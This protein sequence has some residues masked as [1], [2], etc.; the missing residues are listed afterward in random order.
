MFPPMIL[1]GMRSAGIG[2]ID[3]Y[4]TPLGHRTLDAISSM[5]SGELLRTLADVST[6]SLLSRPLDDPQFRAAA[7]AYMQVPTTG[8]HAPILLILNTAD[9]T[10][11]SPLHAMLVAEFAAAGVDFTTAVGNGRHSSTNPAQQAAIWSFLAR[12]MR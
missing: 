1:A 10:V 5:C 11:P 7:D 3:S 6:G 4:L 12:V 8:Y 9:T 2:D